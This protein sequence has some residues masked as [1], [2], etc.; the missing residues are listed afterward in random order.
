Y[1]N[2]PATHPAR[3]AWGPEGIR[4]RLEE[5]FTPDSEQGLWCWGCG[6]P[7]GRRWG[8]PLWPLTDSPSHVNNQPAGGQAACRSCRIAVWALPYA[9]GVAGRCLVTVDGDVGIAARAA[10]ANTEVART[11][12]RERWQRWQGPDPLD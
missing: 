2:S 3:A 4:A 6:A 8:K 11:C 1:P 7:A 12:L 9:S 5:L 10:A